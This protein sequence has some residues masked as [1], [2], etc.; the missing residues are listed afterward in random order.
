MKQNYFET[1][2]GAVVLFVAGIFLYIA[3]TMSAPDLL[4]GGYELKAKFNH[5]DGISMGN[6]IRIAGVKVGS[7]Q[8]IHL[9]E[10]TYEAV[11]TFRLKNSLH[12]PEDSSAEILSDGLMGG[13]FI[14]I[15]PGGAKETLKPSEMIDKTQSS[16][17]LEQL[18]S[19]F[20]FSSSNEKN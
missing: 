16:V 15:T 7:V 4:S 18:L 12:I 1:I 5:I 13:K 9:D 8:K 20:M 2:L 3:Y 11:V 17:G 14:N 6:D 10:K 19:K